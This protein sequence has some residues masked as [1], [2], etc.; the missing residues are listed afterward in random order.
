MA[1]PEAITYDRAG[2]VTEIEQELKQVPGALFTV[3]N[4]LGVDPDGGGVPD[5]T[6]TVKGKAELATVAEAVA[7]VDT[8]RIV[9]PAGLA[10]AL[11]AGGATPLAPKI[12]F[13][14]FAT[15]AAALTASNILVNTF[16]EI[17]VITRNTNGKYDITFSGPVLETNRTFVMGESYYDTASGQWSSHARI[18]STSVVRFITA[19]LAGSIGDVTLNNIPVGILVWP[20]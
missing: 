19:A 7:G 14:V 3:R 12:F 11:L 5:A 18:L 13:G 8:T 2:R 4:M 16:G 9:T 15:E 20:A 10:A 17:P 6:E 1:L